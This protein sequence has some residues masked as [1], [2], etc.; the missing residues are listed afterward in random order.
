MRGV[1]ID[2]VKHGQAAAIRNTSREL[3][4][5][6]KLPPEEL[7]PIPDSGSAALCRPP[8]PGWL[9]GGDG[10]PQDRGVGVGDP[11]C[12]RRSAD[13]GRGRH[14][15]CFRIGAGTGDCP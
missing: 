15:L 5:V 11:W 2:Q 1:V 10:R 14:G 13:I 3:L 7:A 9:V 8:D 4:L 6:V 12:W